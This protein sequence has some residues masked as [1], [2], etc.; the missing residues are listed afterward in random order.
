LQRPFHF[1]SANFRGAFLRMIDPLTRWN[2]TSALGRSP[3]REAVKE[4]PA[5]GRG[6]RNRLPHL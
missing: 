5:S 1:L 6:R 2:S 4:S 3:N